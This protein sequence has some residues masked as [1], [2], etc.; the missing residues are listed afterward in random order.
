MFSSFLTCFKP[1]SH[2]PN[3]LHAFSNVSVCSCPHY[4]CF[5]P[6]FIHFQPFLTIFDMFSTVLTCFQSHPTI[7]ICFQLISHVLNPSYVFPPLSAHFSVVFTSLHIFT[8][9]SS[10]TLGQ[11]SP[12]TKKEGTRICRVPCRMALTNK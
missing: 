5:Q 2:A 10:W 8:D 1:V 9:P 11:C 12:G 6:N 7:T 3:L 4:T